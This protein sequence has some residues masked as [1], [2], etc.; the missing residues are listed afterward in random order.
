MRL[1]QLVAA[2]D[3]LLDLHPNVTVL[4]GLDADAHR[5]L[6]DAVQGLA[7]GSAPSGLGL[8]EAHGVLFDLSDEM[9]ALLD[10]SAE[11]LRPVVVASDLPTQGSDPRARERVVAERTLAELEER[12]ATA[13]EE[14]GRRQQARAAAA[15]V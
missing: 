12:R 1:L 5:L 9:L 15:D 14:L 4:A 7:R 11:G 13:G 10:I 3:R 2:R 6:V 8:L